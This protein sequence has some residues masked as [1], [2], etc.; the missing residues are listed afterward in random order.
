MKNRLLNVLSRR[1][2]SEN[3]AKDASITESESSMLG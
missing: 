2:S 3:S 1:T